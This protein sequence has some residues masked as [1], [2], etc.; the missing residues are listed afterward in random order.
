VITVATVPAGQTWIVKEVYVVNAS[1]SSKVVAAGA[2]RPPG[3]L[4]ISLTDG[5]ALAP[6]STEVQRGLFTVLEPGDEL[7]L[8]N[9]TA[10]S[11]GLWI[12]GAALDGVA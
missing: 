12:S 2:Q 6:Y 11:A 8:Y 7:F 3:V 9:S 1:G 4:G 5:A 10:E